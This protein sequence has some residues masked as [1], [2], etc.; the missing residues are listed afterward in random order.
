MIRQKKNGKTEKI[1]KNRYQKAAWKNPLKSDEEDKERNLE[2]I[3][4]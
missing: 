1:R 2:K 4:Q 3:V